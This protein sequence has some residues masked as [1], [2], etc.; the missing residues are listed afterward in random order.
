MLL[1]PVPRTQGWRTI[2]T[3]GWSPQKAESGRASEYRHNTMP[4]ANP[5]AYGG[6]AWFYDRVIE[7]ISAPLRR[8][9][10]GLLPITPTT[11]VLDVGCG[12]GG[13]VAAYADAGAVV[14]GIDL[15]E[16]MLEQAKNRVRDRTRLEVG[17]ATALPYADASFDIVVAS[18]ML[19][20]LERDTQK[21]VIR[22]M[23]RVTTPGG[24]IILIDYRVGKLRLK[25]KGMR[26]LSTI[27]E[28]LAGKDHYRNWR[29]YMATG[30]MPALLDDLDMTVTREKIVAGGNLSLWI[31]TPPVPHRRP[32]PETAPE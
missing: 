31:S 8:T 29:S 18:L 5:D 13:L 16:A 10:V 2:K 15:S 1:T 25:G 7:P 17:D 12:T 28:R 19:H 23:V 32:L 30:G 27:G 9:T 14:S 3:W 24:S 22:A 6:I 26:V 20:E 21:K 4:D 11:R